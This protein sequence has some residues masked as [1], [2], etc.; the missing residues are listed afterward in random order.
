MKRIDLVRH[1][2]QNGCELLRQ[3]SNHTMYVNRKTP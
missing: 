1:L 3:G 2:E